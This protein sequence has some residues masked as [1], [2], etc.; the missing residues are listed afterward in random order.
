MRVSSGSQGSFV[1]ITETAETSPQV[2]SRSAFSLWSWLL[3]SSAT[4]VSLE[5]TGELPSIPQIFLISA[6]TLAVLL[7]SARTITSSLKLQGRSIQGERAGTYST[8]GY[9]RDLPALIAILTVAI[10]QSVSVAL[11][12]HLLGSTNPTYAQ[13]LTFGIPGITTALII[14][15]LTGIALHSWKRVRVARLRTTKRLA[16]EQLAG[17]HAALQTRGKLH[18]WFREQMQPFFQQ[19]S[20]TPEQMRHISASIVRPA[21]H[22]LARETFPTNL[23]GSDFSVQAETHDSRRISKWRDFLNSFRSW[24]TDIASRWQPPS[25]TLTPFLLLGLIGPALVVSEGWGPEVIM[26][27]ALALSLW[28]SLQVLNAIFQGINFRRTVAISL[29]TAFSYLTVAVLLPPLVRKGFLEIGIPTADYFP[30]PSALIALGLMVDTLRSTARMSVP[31]ESKLDEDLQTQTSKVLEDRQSQTDAVVR[32][33]SRFLHGTVQSALIT[34]AL[35]NASWQE[36]RARVMDLPQQRHHHPHGH[37]YHLE[38][39]ELI[40]FWT[41][42]LPLKVDTESTMLNL[43]LGKPMIAEVFFDAVT[44]CLT[45]ALKHTSGELARLDLK[46]TNDGPEMTIVSGKIVRSRD[47]QTSS[48]GLGHESLLQSGL[49]VVSEPIANNN[50]QVTLGFGALVDLT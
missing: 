27:I 21:S 43:I 48:K 30:L 8:L 15:G 44:E 28:L 19:D 40:D 3:V 6:V 2:F 9:S 35:T 49:V 17:Q 34:G 26:L 37:D 18:H 10:V 46:P 14:A 12:S 45:N 32:E 24:S 5:V 16:A 31:V 36:V 23:S 11:T 7:G 25:P 4:W 42:A 50:Y 29:I 22:A 20:L 38:W 41:T 1:T 47:S 13:S 33:Y 39:D